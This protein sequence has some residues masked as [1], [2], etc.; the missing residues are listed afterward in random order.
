[1][2]LP[3]LQNYWNGEELLALFKVWL[4][5]FARSYYQKNNS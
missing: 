5:L 2:T 4:L 1:M 3:P